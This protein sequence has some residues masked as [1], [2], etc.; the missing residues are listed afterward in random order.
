MDTEKLPVGPPGRDDTSEARRS[1]RPSFP[2]INWIRDLFIAVA[3]ALAIIT[4]VYQPVKVEGTSMT[5]RLS[6]QERIFINKFVYTFARIE[7]SD[8]VVFRFPRD[9]R[10]SFIKRVVAMPG[11]AVEIRE[12]IVHINGQPLGEEYLRPG[13]RDRSSFPRLRLPQDHYFVLG[14]RRRSSNDS[15]TWGTVHRDYIYGK[16]VFSYWPLER[17]G[18]IETANGEVETEVE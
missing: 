17:F 16:A 11:E 12:G 15:R 18:P 6:D 2:A 14:D 8:I 9:P 1:R 10:K 7:R 3:L 13:D 5:P 4:F